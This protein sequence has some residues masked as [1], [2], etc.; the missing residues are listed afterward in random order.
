MKRDTFFKN[1]FDRIFTVKLLWNIG[2]PFVC[3]TLKNIVEYAL[4]PNNGIESFYEITNNSMKRVSKKD[5]K[6]LLENAGLT[7]L[8]K[9]LFLKY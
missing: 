8:S 2:Q 7:E 6:T 3:G 9:K 4:K 5:L 1:E